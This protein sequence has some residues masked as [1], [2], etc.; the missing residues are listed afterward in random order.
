[1]L[2]L[3]AI[4]GSLDL[5]F[6]SYLPLVLRNVKGVMYNNRGVVPMMRVRLRLK[7]WLRRRY[8]TKYDS[9]VHITPRNSRSRKP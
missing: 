8:A 4:G 7:R 1:M 5:R 9:I 2:N 3:L 6:S